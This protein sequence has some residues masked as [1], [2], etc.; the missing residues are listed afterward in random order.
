[1]IPFFALWLHILNRHACNNK[2]K[3]LGVVTFYILQDVCVNVCKQNERNCSETRLKI[4]PVCIGERLFLTKC[5]FCTSIY[6]S[7]QI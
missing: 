4:C 1:M 5:K 3:E 7:R 6:Q 2:K